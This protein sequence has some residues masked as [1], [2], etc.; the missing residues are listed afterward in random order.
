M[1]PTTIANLGLAI[2]GSNLFKGDQTISGSI[3][4]SGSLLISESI[5]QYASNVSIAQDT[6]ENIFLSAT[7]SYRAG[8]FDFVATSGSNA[9]AGTVFTVWN[10]TNVEYVETSTGDIGNT[11]T[12]TLSASLLG[13]DIRLQGTSTFGTWSVK[14]L[15][16]LI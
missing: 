16:K 12:L 9:R 10:K 7:G 3:I 14:T 1:T 4:I 15:V 11:S 6:T 5:T 8:F 13:P 2:T